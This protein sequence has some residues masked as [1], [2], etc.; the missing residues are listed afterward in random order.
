MATHAYALQLDAETPPLVEDIRRLWEVSA[1][2]LDLAPWTRIGESALFAVE[3]EPGRLFWGHVMGELGE[4]LR[5][6]FYEGAAGYRLVQDLSLG[7]IEDSLDIFVRT[8]QIYVD[9]EL[10]HEIEPPDKEAISLAGV[11]VRPGARIPVWRVARKNRLPWYPTAEEARLLASCLEL[12]A[13]FLTD[14]LAPRSRHRGV[15]DRTGAAPKIHLNG[16]ISSEPFPGDVPVIAPPPVDE[17]AA[18]KLAKLKKDARLTFEL[19]C[20]AAPIPIGEPG[21]RD[22]IPHLA[23]CMEPSFKAHR[24]LLEMDSDRGEQLVRCLSQTIEAL[25]KRPKEVRVKSRE[26]ARLIAP[27][28]ERS[29]IPVLVVAILPA[30]VS[31]RT[32]L[33]EHIGRQRP[34]PA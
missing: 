30:A 2:L 21:R 20:F 1:R 18:A 9:F 17:P 28:C 22:S 16:S 15:F 14:Y 4:V 11:H 26:D 6:Q 25:G 23:I 10:P 32:N 29:G 3:P 5:L 33:T 34:T 27:F 24:P 13:A 19:D 7:R 31:F 12:S 8:L